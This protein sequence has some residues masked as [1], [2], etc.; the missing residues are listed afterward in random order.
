MIDGQRVSA[1]GDRS[2]IGPVVALTSLKTPNRFIGQQLESG[3]AIG[4]QGHEGSVPDGIAT[5][6]LQRACQN[7]CFVRVVVVTTEEQGSRAR[8]G[9]R[10]GAGDDR[11]NLEGRGAVLGDNKLGHTAVQGATKDPRSA[12]RHLISHQDTTG[13][14]LQNTVGAHIHVGAPGSVEAQTIDVDAIHQTGETRG[15]ICNM[16]AR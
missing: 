4:S 8:L 9:E 5:G 1:N 11:G 7:L 3:G 10:I 12:R 15:F 13:N 14:D 6:H 16:I 2:E